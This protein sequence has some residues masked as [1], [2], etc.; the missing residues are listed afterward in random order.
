MTRIAH[1]ANMYGPKSGGLRTTMNELSLQYA[2]LGHTVLLIVPGKKDSYEN[3]GA[4][5][6]ITVAAP[7]IP[8][9][10]GYRMILKPKKV[11][12]RLQDFR[13]DILEI[14]DRT[15]LL[16]VARWARSRGIPTTFFAHERVDGIVRSFARYLPFQ[17]VLVRRWNMKTHDSVGRIVA[18]TNFAAEEFQQLGLKVDHSPKAKLVSIP[19]GVDLEKFDPRNSQETDQSAADCPSEY[20]FACTRLSKE[21]DPFFLL[22]IATELKTRG[23]TT[24]LIIAGRGPLESKMKEKIERDNLNVRLLGFVSDRNMLSRMMSGATTFLAV[25][26]IETFGLAAL[27]TLASGT[28]VICRA[29]AAISEII[30][31]RSGRALHRSAFDWADAIAE[32]DGLDREETRTHARAR[33]EKFTWKETAD[34]LLR[35]YRWDVAS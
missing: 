5:S 32:F 22:D 17:S 31:E 3:S 19:L 14:S 12:G 28:P 15:T 11:I 27:E 21:K 24:P 2:K 30:D 25:G 23:V 34:Q 10:G 33:A 20:I 6:R 13:P 1:I 16:T 29:E 8:F 26:P 35:F 4:I 18:T 9:S 7:Q